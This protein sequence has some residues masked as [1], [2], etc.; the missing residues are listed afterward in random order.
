MAAT[1][2]A[3]FFLFIVLCFF[4]QI[5]RKKPATNNNLPHGSFVW[6]FLGETI[7]FVRTQ[8]HGVPEKFMRNR[9]E[10]YGSPMVFKTLLLGHHMAVFVGLRGTNFCLETRTN[11]WCR[12]PEAIQ[13]MFG[14]CL[15]TSRGDEALYIYI[16]IHARNQW[17]KW[18]IRIHVLFLAK[19]I[20]TNI[21]GR[22]S[23]TFIH[24]VLADN[25]FGAIHCVG[26]AY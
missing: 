9:M 12:W 20:G 19:T 8:R 23:S 22:F 25:I 18:W 5:H 15:N 13:M 10:R 24:M 1:L 16:Y 7:E 3:L 14:K 4:L 2:L 6:S 26:K 21:I 17:L 11:W